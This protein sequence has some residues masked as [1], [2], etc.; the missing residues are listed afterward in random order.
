MFYHAAINSYMDLIQG[1]GHILCVSFSRRTTRL[2]GTKVKTMG[3][4]TNLKS[5]TYIS[6]KKKKNII[7]LL[8]IKLLLKT[9]NSI[10]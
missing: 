4:C 1:G 9:V 10:T 7:R 3:C 6:Q 2:W 5:K 8:N